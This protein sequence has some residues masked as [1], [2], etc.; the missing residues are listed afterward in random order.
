MALIKYGPLATEV[1]GAIG[2]TVFARSHSQKTVR[3]IR[4]PANRRTARQRQTRNFLAAASARWRNALTAAQR[5]A[6]D[7]YAATREFTNPLGDPYYLTGFASFVQLNALELLAIDSFR[8]AA[9][10]NTGFP[11]S[12]TITWELDHSNR[13]LKITGVAPTVLS[14]SD[15]LY[16][17]VHNWQPISQAFPKSPVLEF[18]DLVGLDSLPQTAYTYPYAFPGSAGSIQAHVEYRWRDSV[19]RLSKKIVELIPSEEP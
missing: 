10:T 1:S 11:Q 18:V 19:Y 15:R 3:S 2:G 12:E 5:A 16:I 6:W 17:F 13:T 14:S 4:L 9:P 8:D 7:T